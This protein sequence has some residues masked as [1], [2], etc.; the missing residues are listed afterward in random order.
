[1]EKF[2]PRKPTLNQIDALLTL[3]G[4][5]CLAVVIFHCSIPPKTIIYQNHDLT[6][7]LVTDGIIAVWVFFALSGY[8]MGK[9]FYSHRYQANLSGLKNFYLNRILRIC[10]LYY[11]SS[12]ILAIFIYP[13]IFLFSNWGDLIRLS[14]FTMAFPLPIITNMDWFNPVLWS[15]ST[16]VQ[17]YLMVPFIYNL[18]SPILTN[19]RKI[20]TATVLLLII[21]FLLRVWGFITL[22]FHTSLLLNMDIFLCGFFLNAWFN[23]EKKSPHSP[24]LTPL[25]KSKIT[26]LF[27]LEI[28]AILL[29]FIFYLVSAYHGYHEELWNSR[30][31]RPDLLRGSLFRTAI[32]YYLWPSLTALLTTFFIY[33]FERKLVQKKHFPQPLSLPACQKNP[34]R[35]L[36]ITGILSYGVYIWHLPII[37]QVRKIIG[38]ED[39]LITFFQKLFITLL[40]ST[41]LSTVTYYLI[42]KPA[43]KLKKFSQQKTG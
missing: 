5:A 15:L 27:S 32:N 30:Q 21:G 12:L 16:E 39:T 2:P 9:A 22:P 20:L 28:I 31:L 11:S 26:Q 18:F 8:L 1:M 6:W 25:P 29:L 14:T 35:L 10:P 4:L 42:E 7:L 13:T 17:F 33:A 24:N 43:A 3:R 37:D 38:S 41:I 36:E 23:I 34:W 40:L 19:K